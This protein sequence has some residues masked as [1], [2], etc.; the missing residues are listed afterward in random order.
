MNY[1]AELDVIAQSFQGFLKHSSLI[2]LDE[3]QQALI[4]AGVRKDNGGPSW[5]VLVEVKT[6]F[7]SLHEADPCYW[8][9]A[10]TYSP[11]ELAGETPSEQIR[12][13]QFY[14]VLIELECR[15]GVITSWWRA[16][17]ADGKIHT[18][19]VMQK[20]EGNGIK[21][22]LIDTANEQEQI[23]VFKELVP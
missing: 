5:S 7:D 13:S 12:L 11:V 16:R 8:L 17:L 3:I 20:L 22:H 23:F 18:K 10:K 6:P 1:T 19:L 14:D 15:A 2:K 21:K 9:L 4:E